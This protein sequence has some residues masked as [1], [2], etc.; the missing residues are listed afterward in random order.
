MSSKLPAIFGVIGLISILA[1]SGYYFMYRN[2]DDNN[3][4]TD[5]YGANKGPQNNRVIF[6]NA[7]V[8]PEPEGLINNYFGGKRSKKK[9]YSRKNKSKKNGKK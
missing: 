5:D 3:Y 1:G 6:S 2:K 9:K 4:S 7:K 8:N